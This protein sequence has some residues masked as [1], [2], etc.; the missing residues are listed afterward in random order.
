M[1]LNNMDIIPFIVPNLTIEQKN[2][3]Q[4]KLNQ[5]IFPNELKTDVG[6]EYGK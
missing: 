3:L 5:S 1:T 6:W 4:E 2:V